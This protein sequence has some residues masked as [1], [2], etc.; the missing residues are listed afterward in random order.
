MAERVFKLSNEMVQVCNELIHDKYPDQRHEH[1][2]TQP[3]V[4]TCMGV[5]LDA[6]QDILTLGMF[7]QE[8]MEEQNQEGTLCDSEYEAAY[9][10]FQD[11][12]VMPATNGFAVCWPKIPYIVLGK[13]LKVS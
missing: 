7:I 9:I 11:A 3:T 2:L 8:K 4:L 13:K 1:I 10:V 5:R 6:L 12:T